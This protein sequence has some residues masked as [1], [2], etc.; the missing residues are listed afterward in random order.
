LLPDF[1]ACSDRDKKETEK[2]YR[3]ALMRHSA[4]FI[5]WERTVNNCGKGTKMCPGGF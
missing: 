3:Q 2:R 4:W 1:I 5:N